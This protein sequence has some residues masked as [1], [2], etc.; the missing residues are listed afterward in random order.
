MKKEIKYTWFST[1]GQLNEWMNFDLVE[2]IS[3]QYDTKLDIHHLYY[4]YKKCLQ[5]PNIML[6]LSLKHYVKIQDTSD[7]PRVG[8]IYSFQTA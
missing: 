5:N 6:I 8:W 4:T 1:I 2:I 7:L 3:I